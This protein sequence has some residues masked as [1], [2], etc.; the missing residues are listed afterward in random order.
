VYCLGAETG[1]VIWEY[2]TAGPVSSS[3]TVVDGVVYIGSTDRRV[4]A[5]RA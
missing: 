5:L 1:N 3:P 4:Y 2:R